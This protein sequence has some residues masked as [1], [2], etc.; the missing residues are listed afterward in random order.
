LQGAR[1]QLGIA[2]GIQG[3]EEVGLFHRRSQQRED[4]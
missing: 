3:G 2:D 1:N 4:T